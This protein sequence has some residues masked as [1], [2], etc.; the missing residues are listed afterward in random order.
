MRIAFF[1]GSVDISGG[2]YV[3]FQ[4]ALA[5]RE[6]GHEVVIVALLPYHDGMLGW[7]PACRAL[8]IVPID[9]LGEAHFDLAI[10]TWWRTA[11]ALHR[12]PADRYAYFVQSIESWFYDVAE[13]PLR[14]LVDATYDLPLPG[15]TEA[16]WIRAHLEERHGRPFGLARNGIRKDL[17]RPD[18]PL[19]APRLPTGRLRV[20]VEGPF[21]VPFKHVGRTLS[22]MRQARPGETWLLTATDLPWYPGVDRLCSRVSIAE[23]PPLMRACDVLVKLS[24]VEG[25]FGP[26]LEQF[27][28]GGTAVVWDVTGHDEYIVHGHNALVVPRHDGAGVVAAIQRLAAD[29]ALLARLKAGARETAEAWPDWGAAS[30]VFWAVLAEQVA[31]TPSPGRRALR[32]QAEAAEARYIQQ[33]EA[34]LAA[35]PGLRARQ[36]AQRWLDGLPR[37]LTLPLRMGKYLWAGR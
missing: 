24:T 20:L 2:S 37:S 1:I 19:A 23:V 5:A 18:G 30:A 15:V 31:G 8:P 25:M 12:I 28:C 21:G 16:R 6:A 11:L 26:P 32:E 34:R 10:A 3:I 7:H 27:H 33:E 4:H 13:Q 17:Y 36:R 29:P 14:A 22:L 35:Q 9:G